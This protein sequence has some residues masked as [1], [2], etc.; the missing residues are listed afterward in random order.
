MKTEITPVIIPDSVSVSSC[1]LMRMAVEGRAL[2]QAGEVVH[3]VR[4]AG[5]K[6]HQLNSRHLL[7]TYLL[8][9]GK[10]AVWSEHEHKWLPLLVPADHIEKSQLM[11]K[12][13]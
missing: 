3:E 1:N 13:H 6:L 12:I 8:I 2:E 7:A 11:E 10:A 4:D 5:I 9:D